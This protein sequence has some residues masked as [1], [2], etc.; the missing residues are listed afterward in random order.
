MYRINQ[1]RMGAPI[2]VVIEFPWG[3]QRF[4]GDWTVYSWFKG[5]LAPKPLASAFLSLSHWALKQIDAGQSADKVIR[6]VVEHNDCY[7]VLGLALILALET[8][9]VS[10]TTLPLVSC[11]R[12]WEHDTRRLIQE[13]SST[14]PMGYPYHLPY[15]TANR[16]K[17]VSR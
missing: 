13:P 14:R 11:Q 10:E 17:E 2:P 6:L 5:Q 7:A 15:A 9:H 16:S 8:L 3:T 1:T 4:W 12:L